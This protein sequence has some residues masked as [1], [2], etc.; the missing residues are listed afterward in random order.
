MEIEKRELEHKTLYVC[1]NNVGRSQMGEALQNDINPGSA[2][3]A[4]LKVDSPGAMVKDWHGGADVICQ[5]M[6]EIGLPI[7]EKIRSQYDEIEAQRYGMV[8]FMLDYQQVLEVDLD[9]HQFD[10]RFLP[11][12]DPRDMPIERVRE[13]RDN[14]RQNVAILAVN[15]CAELIPAYS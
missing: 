5:S 11:L 15:R 13:I 6:E 1:V 12:P 14:I 7:G 3:S 4:G 2:D 8:V 10:W 9:N